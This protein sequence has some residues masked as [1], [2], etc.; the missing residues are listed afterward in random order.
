MNKL[1][2]AQLVYM[3]HLIELDAATFGAPLYR[4]T[5]G[6]TSSDIRAV[7]GPLLAELK[8]RKGQDKVAAEFA[9][10]LLH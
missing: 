4:T 7:A 2:T 6:A 3:L 8:T 9:A 5:E 10:R 1:T